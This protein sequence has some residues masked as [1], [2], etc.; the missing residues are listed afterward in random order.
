MEKIF[1]ENRKLEHE[2]HQFVERNEKLRLAQQKIQELE[3]ELSDKKE[4]LSASEKTK[5]KLLLE[6]NEIEE[7]TIDLEDK[8][9]KTTARCQAINAQRDEAVAENQ[10]LITPGDANRQSLELL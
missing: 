10:V 8:L 7:K 2:K 9:K 3:K 1:A 4:L 5:L 6:K